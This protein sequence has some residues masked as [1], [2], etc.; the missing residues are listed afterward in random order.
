[1]ETFSQNGWHGTKS[2]LGQLFHGEDQIKP[3]A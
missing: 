1:M 2:P 3:I